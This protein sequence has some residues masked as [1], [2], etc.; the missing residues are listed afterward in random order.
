MLISIAVVA[1]RQARNALLIGHRMICLLQSNDP[2]LSPYAGSTLRA[3]PGTSCC[4]G[5]GA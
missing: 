3:G 1:V 5:L 4:P 2:R